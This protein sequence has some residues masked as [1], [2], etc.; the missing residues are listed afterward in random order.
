LTGATFLPFGEGAGDVAV[1]IEGVGVVVGLAHGT[2]QSLIPN[3]VRSSP[4]R[5]GT[6]SSKSQ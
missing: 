5:I 2:R 3:Q 4:I 6:T 1:D